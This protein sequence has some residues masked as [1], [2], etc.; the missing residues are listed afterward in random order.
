VLDH[1]LAAV[2]EQVGERDRPVGA[3]EHVFLLDPDHRHA[4]ALR[5]KGS[6]P[7]RLLLLQS[8]QPLPGLEPL[9]ARND[10]RQ[11]HPNLLGRD[12]MRD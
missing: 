6:H 5:V 1:Q 8:E 4:A 12:V 3:F 11:S 2:A 9:L 10:L 7:G